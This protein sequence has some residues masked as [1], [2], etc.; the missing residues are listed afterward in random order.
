MKNRPR[1]SEMRT[2]P[3]ITPPMIA[4][5]GFLSLEVEELDDPTFEVELDELEDGTL[6]EV[7][8]LLEELEEVEDAAPSWTK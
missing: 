3:P 5:V 8:E 4:P 7:G 2:S 1:R 6:V